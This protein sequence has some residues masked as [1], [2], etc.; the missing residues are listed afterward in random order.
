MRLLLDTHVFLW[1]LMDDERLPRTA[2]A[3]MAD[4]RSQVYVSA[5][6]LWEIS[7]KVALGKLDVGREDLVAEVGANHFL[8]LPITGTH[9][10]AAGRLP[11]HHG[12]PFDRMLV[13]QAHQ[14]DL[15]FLTGDPW[16]A[17]Y[18]VATL[19]L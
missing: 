9:A 3:A 14:E 6:S 5:A 13:A 4:A 19:N 2:R 15:T 8:D 16:V 7:I 17:Q 18:D 11:R 10:V 12:D 1:W